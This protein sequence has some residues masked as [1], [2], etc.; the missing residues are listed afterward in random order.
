MKLLVNQFRICI[1]TLLLY[2]FLLFGI[3]TYKSPI[4]LTMIIAR[5]NNED[6][7]HLC[8]LLPYLQHCLH[9]GNEGEGG[10]QMDQR[11]FVQDKFQKCCGERKLYFQGD[12]YSPLQQGPCGPGEWLIME[13]G[14]EEGV[15]KKMPCESPIQVAFY[16]VCNQSLR[17]PCLYS[18]SR[19]ES[20][21]LEWT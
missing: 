13:K 10:G 18:F 20:A 6:K 12:C 9:R 7:L 16:L 5:Q 15:C 4:L 1:V 14:R 8:S 17:F 19:T 3:T 2:I 21:S 11:Y